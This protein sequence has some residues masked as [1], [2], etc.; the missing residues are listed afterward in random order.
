MPDPCEYIWLFREPKDTSISLQHTSS[1]ISKAKEITPQI[2]TKVKSKKDT[3]DKLI[4]KQPPISSMLRKSRSPLRNVKETESSIK[5][6]HNNT[7]NSKKKKN[8][9]LG[10]H[11]Q[12]EKISTRATRYSINLVK[13]KF[14]TSKRNSPIKDNIIS[15]TSSLHKVL[16]KVEGNSHRKKTV[17]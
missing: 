15:P 17:N 6:I 1:L 12:D 11:I 8:S 7:N 13:E 16:S 4:I 14:N 5:I 9:V 3:K 2:L 10:Q